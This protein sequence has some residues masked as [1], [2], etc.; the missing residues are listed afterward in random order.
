MQ[1]HSQAK[2]NKLNQEESTKHHHGLQDY[3]NNELMMKWLIDESY[4]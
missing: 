4:G 3:I 2:L 1:I